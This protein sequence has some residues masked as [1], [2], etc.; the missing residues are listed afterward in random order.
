MLTRNFEKKSNMLA[1]L[2]ILFF[3]V[4]SCAE[5]LSSSEDTAKTELSDREDSQTSPSTSDQTETSDDKI[6]ESN[7]CDSETNSEATDCEKIEILAPQCGKLNLANSN[8]TTIQQFIDFVNELPK[9]VTVNC[10]LEAIERPLTIA[11]TS[12]RFS[13][14]GATGSTSPRIF[15]EKGKLIMTFVPGGP[16][17]FN[18]ELAETTTSDQ[19]I[20][21]DLKFP[22]NDSLLE[23]SAFISIY[24]GGE[25]ACANLC[26]TSFKKLQ[27]YD[28]GSVKYSSNRIFPKENSI[29]P[30]IDLELF[31]QDCDSVGSD[32]CN[33]YRSLFDHGDVDKFVFPSPTNDGGLPF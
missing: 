17:R 18:I 11:A 16:E 30:L 20:K 32:I 12:N 14:Q 15:V 21:G 5:D 29:V 28:D 27:T 19:S 22:I 24:G 8:P 2:A 6:N 9:P 1:Y 26:H 13:A 10:V 7:N 25:P 31:R 4:S 3:V 23:Y 33:F